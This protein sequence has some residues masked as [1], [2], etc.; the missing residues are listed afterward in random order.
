LVRLYHGRTTDNSENATENVKSDTLLSP[1]AFA[2]VLLSQNPWMPLDHAPVRKAPLLL[3]A[4]LYYKYA[5]TRLKG[6][7]AANQTFVPRPQRSCTTAHREE[8]IGLHTFMGACTRVPLHGVGV[9]HHGHPPWPGRSCGMLFP[10]TCPIVTHTLRRLHAYE[11]HATVRQ[12]H[13]SLWLQ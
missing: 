12:P 9:C 1:Q 13:E 11:N 4:Y 5:Y 8:E 7:P 6:C 3:Q 2:V 10:I